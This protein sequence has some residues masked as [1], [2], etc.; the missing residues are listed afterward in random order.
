[1][2]EE[3]VIE[4]H[5][6]PVIW[7]SNPVIVPKSDGKL[8]I[9]AD[10]RQVNKA[11]DNTHLPIPRVQDILPMFAGKRFCSKPDLRAAFHQVELAKESRHLTVFRAGEKLKCYKRLT[12]G[13]LPASGELNN[14]LHPILAKIADAEIIHDDIVIASEDINAHNKTLHTVLKMIQDVCLTL[15]RQKCIFAAESIP[16]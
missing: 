2:E 13:S 1:M 10:L 6:G 16:F 8:R 9:T 5:V 15:N 4:D 14:R 12:M 7:I 11:L 3:G